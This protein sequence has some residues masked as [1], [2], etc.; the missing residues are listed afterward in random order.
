MVGFVA[1][2]TASAAADC[3]PGR[4]PAVACGAGVGHKV[5][6]AGRVVRDGA[7]LR[8]SWPGVYFE[9]RFRGTGIGIVLTDPAADY[10]I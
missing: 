8:F 6:T 5:H 2:P 7:S 9:G 4:S 1:A 3:A 10:E